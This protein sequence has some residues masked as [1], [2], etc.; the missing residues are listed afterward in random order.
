MSVALLLG[1]FAL[2]FLILLSQKIK[3]NPRTVRTVAIWILAMRIVDITWTIGPVFRHEG[4]SLHWLDFA[5]VLGMG[6]LWLV[7]FWRNLAGRPLVPARDP[8]LKEALAHGG[9]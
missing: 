8:Y 7:M 1:Q 4:S 5:V 3:R 6:C 9:H 2:P